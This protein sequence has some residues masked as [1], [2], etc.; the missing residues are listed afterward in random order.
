MFLGIDT[1]CYTT[2]LA[3][4]DTRGRLLSEARTLLTVPQ[5]ERG[6]RQSNGV[7]QHLQNLPQLAEQIKAE[8]GAVG[9]QA[10]AVSSKPRPLPDS[11]MPVFAVGLSYARTLATFFNVSC[12]TLSHQ[13]GH[14]L[15]GIWSA[16]VEWENFYA[17][18]VS[19]GTT[20]LLDVKL[21][22]G[23]EII[24][25]GGSTDLHA[26]QFIDRIGVAMGL[27]FPAGPQLE[28][29]ATSAGGKIVA[30]PVAVD[31]VTMSLSGPESHVQR[32]LATGEADYAAVARGVERC[33][34]ESLLRLSNAASKK[35]GH[36]PIL[37]M[38]GVMANHFI[39]TYLAERIGI[40]CAF[41][42]PRFAGDNAVGAAIYAQRHVR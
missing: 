28:A 8:V 4:V 17:L 20:E 34:A 7:W 19:G 35:F 41:A 32:I 29:L 24:E 27:S 3:V 21:V 14:L 30:V 22:D 12:V 40:L 25:L 36:K 23:M 9:L 11:Y 18:H 37:F 31:G 26:G 10:V 16:Q 33:I 2:S 42:D 6:L 1:S 5:G 15:A 39:R 38:G 13:E